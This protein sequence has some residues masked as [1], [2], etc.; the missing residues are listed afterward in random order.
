M[1][2]RMPSQEEQRIAEWYV[3]RRPLTRPNTSFFKAI[4]HI[5]AFFVVTLALH[6]MLYFLLDWL[7]VFSF[8]PDS[9]KEFQENNEV[10]FFI[11]STFLFVFIAA[12][13]MAKRAI[14]G[15][16]RLYQRYAP[17]DVRRRCLL[18]PTCSEYAILAIEKYGVIHGLKKTYIRLNKTCRGRTYRIDYP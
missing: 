17:E 2:E 15:M 8:M 9:L 14:I 12:F 18:K 10:Y 5:F 7:G 11:I 13:F 1:N 6:A 3:L 16:I 4:L